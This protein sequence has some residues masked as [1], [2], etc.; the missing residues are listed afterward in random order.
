[1]NN[2]TN[3][4]L[5]FSFCFNCAA[6]FFSCSRTRSSRFAFISFKVTKPK[7][8]N[9]IVNEASIVEAQDKQFLSYTLSKENAIKKLP[10]PPPPLL[11]MTT[12]LLPIVLDFNCCSTTSYCVSNLLPKPIVPDLDSYKEKIS[13]KN[14]ILANYSQFKFHKFHHLSFDSNLNSKP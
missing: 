14:Y 3:S 9:L 10:L 7:H 8:N 2:F 12:C 13:E 5:S 1:M 11:C 6:S 4:Y